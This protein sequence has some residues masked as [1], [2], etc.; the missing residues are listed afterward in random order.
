MIDERQ[1]NLE[2]LCLMHGVRPADVAAALGVSRSM[3]TYWFSGVRRLSPPR[4]Q[5]LADLIHEPLS[6]VHRYYNVNALP[7]FRFPAP[8]ASA[9]VLPVSTS[10]AVA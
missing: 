2:I 7:Q 10:A 5:Q 1:L 8:E 4:D 9:D 6:E 3:V